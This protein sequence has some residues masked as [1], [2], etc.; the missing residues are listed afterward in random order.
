MK[1]R[2]LV[3][4]VTAL[5]LLVTSAGGADARRYASIVIDAHSGTVL[6]ADGADRWVYPASLTKI[7]TLYMLFEAVDEGRFT[8]N[9]QLRVSRRAAGMPPSKLGLRAGESIR[10]RDA[11][12]ALVTK[13]A[14]DVAVVVAEALA[15]SEAAF[16]RRMTERARGL[17][18]RATTFRN[19]SGLPNSQQRTT[20]RDMARLA[21]QLQQ[22]FPDFYSV[23]A[24]QRFSYG[25]RS[26][27]NHNRLLESY[28]G[29]DGIK[30][31]YIRASGF[32]LVAS[33]LRDGR[34]LI[35]VV[36]GGRTSASRNAHMVT[37][38]DRGFAEARRRLPLVAFA[39]SPRRPEV[40]Q[41]RLALADP[42]QLTPRRRPVTAATAASGVAAMPPSAPPLRVTVAP[43][44]GDPAPNAPIYGID[45][46]AFATAQQAHRAADAVGAI[47]PLVMA[48]ASVEV[49]SVAAG[50]RT[51]YRARRMGLD[52]DV[53]AAVCDALN[54]LGQGCD[55]IRRSGLTT[56][57][58]DRGSS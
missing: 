40:L 15:G 45:L 17:G 50:E 23:F 9:S 21:R 51:R 13:S 8:L 35:A 7:M 29:T 36:V 5:L 41:E 48:D 19:A 11:I 3:I 55:M 14:N 1:P 53:A 37:L 33:V 28:D 18:L 43:E 26:Y 34:R 2:Y 52:P 54:Q 4:I 16:A 32:N 58:V 24:M 12:G 22:D 27:R 30:T 44:A 49:S 6:H 39:P 47:A 20:A 38:L 31:G 57:V 46:G 42:R 56:A 25:G 10:V